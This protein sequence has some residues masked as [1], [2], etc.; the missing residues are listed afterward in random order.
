MH[1]TKYLKSSKRFTMKVSLSPAHLP[2]IQF[3][4]PVATVSFLYIFLRDVINVIYTN[5]Y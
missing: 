1:R 4:C 5:T 3:P 2:A